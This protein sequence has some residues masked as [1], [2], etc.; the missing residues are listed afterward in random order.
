MKDGGDS[1]SQ[2]VRQKEREEE[3][4]ERWASG[5]DKPGPIISETWGWVEAV[6]AATAA[7]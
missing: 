1:R 5:D 7:G 4:K 3:R 2:T 6:L